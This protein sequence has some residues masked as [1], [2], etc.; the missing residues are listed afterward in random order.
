MV[1]T[2]PPPLP[3]LARMPPLPKVTEEEE[4]D[5]YKERPQTTLPPPQQHYVEFPRPVSPLSQQGHQSQSLCFLPPLFRGGCKSRR[6]LKWQLCLEW[7]LLRHEWPWI[8][9]IVVME[10]LHAAACNL[11]YYAQGQ[12]YHYPHD[13]NKREHPP[14]N[15]PYPPIKDLGFMALNAGHLLPASLEWVTSFFMATLITLMLLLWLAR[16]VLNVRFGGPKT[17]LTSRDAP[18]RPIILLPVPLVLIIK[19]V[20]MAGIVI[21]PLRCLTFLPTLLPPPARHCQSAWSPPTTMRQILDPFSLPLTGCGDSMFSG[22]TLHGTLITLMVF[23]YFSYYRLFPALASVILALLAFSLIIFRF[24]YTADVVTALYVTMGGWFLLP[25]EPT[26]LN[27]YGLY[28]NVLMRPTGYMTTDTDPHVAHEVVQY[29]EAGETLQGET[30]WEEK[31]DMAEGEG[32]REGIASRCWTCGQRRQRRGP[33]VRYLSPLPSTGP[34]LVEVEDR[35]AC[36]RTLERPS[37]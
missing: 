25:R 16:L 4:E 6:Q 35:T 5:Q 17:A 28:A 9:G 36:E 32:E 18:D 2:T 15:F 14:T 3:S 26:T 37:C 24:H 23:R 19:R 34:P 1:Q 30:L 7:A 29:L 22:H 20:A 10:Y 13:D 27:K 33:K 21:I 12:V 11:V 8:L 31:E